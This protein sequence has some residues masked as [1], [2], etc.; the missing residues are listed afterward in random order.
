MTDVLKPKR[1]R[2][3]KRP[4]MQD[5]DGVELVQVYDDASVQ[6]VSRQDEQEVI[7]ETLDRYSHRTVPVFYD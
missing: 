1:G 7:R 6:Q 2:P 5:L 3:V 4:S